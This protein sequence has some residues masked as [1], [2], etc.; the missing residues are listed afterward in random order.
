[1]G[2]G[3]IWWACSGLVKMFIRVWFGGVGEDVNLIGYYIT[4]LP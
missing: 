3:P 4:R 2:G 1:M